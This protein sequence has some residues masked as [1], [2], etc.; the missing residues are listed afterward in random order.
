MQQ[1]RRKRWR[2]WRRRSGRFRDWRLD[3]VH[4]H[5]DEHGGVDQGEP[6]RDPAD[7]AQSLRTLHVAAVTRGAGASRGDR[8]CDG[9][10][11]G[12]SDA[13]R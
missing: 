6:V 11:H 9:D 4:A 1:R 12:R 13:E 5:S 3:L 7:D 10:E 8:A 2:H